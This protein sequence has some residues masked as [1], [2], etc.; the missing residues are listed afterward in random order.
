MVS[1]LLRSG[2]V[3]PCREDGS[4]PSGADPA[5]GTDRWATQSVT[6]ALFVIE[7]RARAHVPSGHGEHLMPWNG[8]DRRVVPP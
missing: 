5:L 6:A 3:A 7:L 2:G 8:E 1:H 4:I